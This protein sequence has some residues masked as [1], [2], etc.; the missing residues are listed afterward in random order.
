MKLSFRQI[1]YTGCPLI[2]FPLLFHTPCTVLPFSQINITSLLFRYRLK[3]SVEDHTTR[4][5]FALLGLTV[6]RILPI[7]AADLA[8]A[9]PEEYGPIPPPL[10]FL[11][12][13]QGLVIP[14]AQVL[15]CLPPPPPPR[16][17]RSC[18]FLFSH[19][20]FSIHRTYLMA[21]LCSFIFQPAASP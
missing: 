18:L 15:A 19:I 21:P 17:P 14:R 4:T 11:I 6:E 3:L 5:T 2:F 13:Q 7:S 10:Q 16:S 12:G 8:R 9:Y 1:S 20:Q